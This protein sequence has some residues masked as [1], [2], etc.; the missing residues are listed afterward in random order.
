MFA[1]Y[2]R[3][4]RDPAQR[5][6]RVV[7]RL[8]EHLPGGEIGANGKA[9]VSMAEDPGLGA[10]VRSALEP[11]S[12]SEGLTPASGVDWASQLRAPTLAKP[13]ELQNRKHLPV[14]AAGANPPKRKGSDRSLIQEISACLVAVVRLADLVL[15]RR[16]IADRGDEVAHRRAE[17][18][19]RVASPHVGVLKD[20]MQ[21]AGGPTWSV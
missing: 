18:R 14:R 15:D 9:L 17:A 16:V 4:L 21:D 7:D 1:V 11:K 19:L 3:P 13:L 20:V 12:S 10:R 8:R 5:P 6:S 2:R